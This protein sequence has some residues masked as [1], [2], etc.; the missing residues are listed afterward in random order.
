L[1]QVADAPRATAN[2][3]TFPLKFLRVNAN[4]IARDR[5]FAAIK[6]ARYQR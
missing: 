2:I 5:R 3:G 6:A 4:L 1:P